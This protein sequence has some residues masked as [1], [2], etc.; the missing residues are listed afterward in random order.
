[1]ND[2]KFDKPF[3]L[4]NGETLCDLN[5]HYTTSGELNDAKDNVVWVCHA[6]TAN[7]NPMEWWPGLVGQGRLIDPGQYYIVCA[8]ILGSC[9]GTTG[10]ASSKKQSGKDFPLITIRDMVKAHQLLRAH[11]GIQKIY[12]A[13]GGSLGGQQVLEWAVTE[14]DL[15]DHLCLLATNALHSPWGIAFN[16]AQRMA[17]EADPTLWSDQP[18]AGKN[19]IETARA[20]AMLSYR[21]YKT[22]KKT[23]SE[24]SSHKT[25]DFLAS[26]Y[27][28]YQGVKLQKRFHPWAYY[29]LSRSMD[30][31]HL[32]RGRGSAEKALQAIKAKT[33]VI[34]IVSDILFPIEEQQFLARHIQGARLVIIDSDYGH[35]GFLIEYNQIATLVRDFLAGKNIDYSTVTLAKA[36]NSKALPGSE[37]F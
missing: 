11:L 26:S 29:S 37:S 12:M 36:I 27:Q 9:Y 7:A 17:L 28:R 16:E 10:P 25:H 32:G 15:F 24:T 21:H 22:Y 33:L 1:M 18:D 3:V 31:H 2:L 13:I 4:E 8:N 5:I 14:P 34:G 20:I 35:D 30:S 19:G 23:Q 6:L